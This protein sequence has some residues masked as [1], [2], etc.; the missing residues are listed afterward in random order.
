MRVARMRSSYLQ[1]VGMMIL[2]G[3]TR[4]SGRPGGHRPARL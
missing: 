4:S 1:Q 3:G 2:R